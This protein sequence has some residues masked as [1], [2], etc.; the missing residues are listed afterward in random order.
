MKPNQM[1]D[2]FIIATQYP[3]CFHGALLIAE[4]HAS[5]ERTGKVSA[6]CY[7]HLGETIRHVNLLLDDSQTRTHH[8]TVAAVAFLATWE[9]RIQLLCTASFGTRLNYF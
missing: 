4:G 1:Q 9:V 5:L 3:A 8:S 7:Y 6:E 2:L